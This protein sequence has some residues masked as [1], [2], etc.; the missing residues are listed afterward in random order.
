[1]YGTKGAHRYSY[2]V[3]LVAWWYAVP[4]G[5]SMGLTLELGLSFPPNQVLVRRVREVELG[6]R[7]VLCRLLCPPL[8]YLV[9]IAF[10]SP[11]PQY[12]PLLI[13]T[14][15]L[16]S[17]SLSSHSQHEPNDGLNFFS[18]QPMAPGPG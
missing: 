1:M 4:E 5:Y 13:L 12:R 16:F 3:A 2:A 15:N 10:I 18:A 11:H 7:V 14:L 17:P 9:S 8:Y 6:C